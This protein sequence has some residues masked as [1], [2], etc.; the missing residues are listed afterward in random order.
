MQGHN[1]TGIVDHAR[2]MRCKY[3]CDAGFLVQLLH[4]LH[5]LFAVLR[6][7]IGSRFIGEN[8]NLDSMPMHEPRRRVVVRRRSIDR[9]DDGR[10]QQDQLIQEAG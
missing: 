2:I 7:E 6:I 10:G 4:D 1:S 9:D 8:R 3:K 5:D